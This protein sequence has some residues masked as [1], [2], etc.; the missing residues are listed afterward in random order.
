MIKKYLI[1]YTEYEDILRVIGHETPHK[2]LVN[3]TMIIVDLEEEEMRKVVSAGF[4]VSENH[5]NIKPLYVPPPIL[6]YGVS[7]TYIGEFKIIMNINNANDAGF[8]GTG[9]SVAI[10][11]TGCND[12]HAAAIPGIIRLDFT[13]LGPDGDDELHGS[14]GCLM[15]AQ[16]LDLYDATLKNYGNAPGCQL[17]SMRCYEG[18]IAAF[19]EGIEYCITHN[20][21]IINISFDLVGGIDSSIQ[22]ALDAGCIVVCSSGNVFTDPMAYPATYPGTLSVSGVTADTAELF[23]S[24]ITSNHLPKVDI[25]Q[26]AGGMAQTYTGG[27]SQGA[28]MLS[29]MIALYLQKYPSLDTSKTINLLRRR[30]RQMDGYSYTVPSTTLGVNLNYETGAGFINVLN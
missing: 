15:V 19:A 29:G 23:G 26:F 7:P 27:T 4:I 30:A 11:D 2:N 13:G 20:I 5:N 28:F 3:S 1:P 17:T 22:A 14:R 8:D 24:Y 25:V 12:F 16:K 9:T 18:G 6:A 21:K 10:L